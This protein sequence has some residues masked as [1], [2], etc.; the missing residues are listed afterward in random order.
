MLNILLIY[1]IMSIS[2]IRLL[3]VYY[4]KSIQSIHNNNTN[5]DFINMKE[6]VSTVLRSIP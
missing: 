4:S 2:W 5:K 3:T 6:I 1:S